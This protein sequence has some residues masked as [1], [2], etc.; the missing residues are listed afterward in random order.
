MHLL[1][2]VLFEKARVALFRMFVKNDPAKFGF[3][4]L[5]QSGRKKIEAE[6]FGVLPEPARTAV[7]WKLWSILFVKNYFKNS[8]LILPSSFIRCAYEKEARRLWTSRHQVFLFTLCFYFI[9]NGSIHRKRGCSTLRSENLKVLLRFLSPLG[10]SVP[11]CI[12][13]VPVCERV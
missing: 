3:L 2:Q 12:R 13:E 1:K 8:T 9:I 5:L 6:M 11:L 10:F 4:P 7:C